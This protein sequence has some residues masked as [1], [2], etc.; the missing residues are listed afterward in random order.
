LT[1]AEAIALIEAAG[2]PDELF[3]SDAARAYRARERARGVARHGSCGMG[4]GETARYAL[5]NPGD[6]PRVADCAAP[7]T[8]AGKLARLRDR[9]ADE[10][11][12][13]DGPDMDDLCDA[14][15]AFAAREW[16]GFHPYT[17][18]STTLLAEAGSARAA[19]RLGVVRCYPTR[20][21]P[22]PFVTEDPTLEL[23]EPTTSAERGRG[24]SGPGTSTRSRCGPTDRP[25][26]TSA[27]RSAGSWQ[28][29]PAV[30]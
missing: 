12:F 11:G 17:T 23:P 2:G 20:H 29:F 15:R 21:G 5:E 27:W 14:Y 1:F 6:A 7:R 28:A 22:G 24:R 25:R 10:F 26:L 19:L 13:P 3:G 18:W 30:R 8:L 16:R 4:I 9:F